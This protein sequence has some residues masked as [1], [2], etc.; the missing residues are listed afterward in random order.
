MLDHAVA[1][2]DVRLDVLGM[3][4]VYF[5]FFPQ[6]SH[7]DPQG[8]QFRSNTV[9]STSPNLADDVVVGQHLAGV[10]GQQAQQFILN[11]CQ[12]KLCPSRDAHPPA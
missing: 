10:L 3:A 7:K 11:G 6:G 5:Q 2:A 8:R 1:D 12:V 9:G 4:L